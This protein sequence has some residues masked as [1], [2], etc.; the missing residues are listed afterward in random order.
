MREEG[1]REERGRDGREGWG[2]EL[3]STSREVGTGKCLL[4]S[5][6]LR[7]T[8]D[9]QA[10]L[11]GLE[12]DALRIASCGGRAYVDAEVDMR[13]LASLP[14]VKLL[15]RALCASP[16]RAWSCSRTVGAV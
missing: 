11:L 4:F 1:K 16:P 8:E 3:V 15:L 10:F 2:K 6:S 9:S 5:L 12:G 7:E 13:G 14:I